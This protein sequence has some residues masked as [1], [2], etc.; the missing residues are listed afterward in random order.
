MQATDVNVVLKKGA[1]VNDLDLW[2]PTTQLKNLW[3]SADHRGS[4]YVFAWFKSS[5]KNYLKINHAT[6]TVGTH[7]SFKIT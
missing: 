1:Q 7:F 5:N 3:K 6:R 2:P 4:P